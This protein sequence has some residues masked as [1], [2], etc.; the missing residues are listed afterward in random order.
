[1]LKWIVAG[2]LPCLLMQP[3]R[4]LDED[5]N[6]PAF[7]DADV[8]EID[9]AE[10]VRIYR[11]DVVFSQG[12]ARLNCDTLVTSLDDN[13]ELQEAVCTGEPARYQQRPREQDGDI[14]LSALKI[15]LDRVNDRM[16]LENHA[17]I[18]QGDSIVTGNKVIYNLATGKARI[19]GSR[20][21]IHSDSGDGSQ[22]ASR[23]RTV[24]QPGKKRTGDPGAP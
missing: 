3:A 24:I 11:G 18:E 16:V 22:D 13:E 20:Q 12:S 7:L 14:R 9:F 23:V 15:T 19:T 17:T 4:A 6:Q 10:G 5:A 8:M 2:L 1:M 21:S